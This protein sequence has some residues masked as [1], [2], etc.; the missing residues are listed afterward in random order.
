MVTTY[1]LNFSLSGQ[2]G[3]NYHLL[4][5]SPSKIHTQVPRNIS[6]TFPHFFS[7]YSSQF[8]KVFFNFSQY[9]IVFSRYLYAFVRLLLCI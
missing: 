4:L 9:L 3:N 6:Q 1:S 8:I 2:M 7:L 5:L